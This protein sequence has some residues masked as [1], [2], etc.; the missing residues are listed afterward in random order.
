MG[1]AIDVVW[2][3][4]DWSSWESLAQAALMA[5]PRPGVYLG[6]RGATGE[7]LYVGHA[8]ERVHSQPGLRGRLGV[9][10]R[11]RGAVSGLGEAA[12][13]RALADPAFVRQRL[14]WLE[15]GRA[16]RTKDWARAALSWANVHVC[17]VERATKAE[18][19]AFED[20]LLGLLEAHVLWNR[21]RPTPGGAPGS[22]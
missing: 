18:A 5:P 16:E 12:L 13:D 14:H 1:D 11:G 17:W 8:G 4:A 21:K 9:Y 10:A 6:R 15:T 7:L 3:R 19:A 22:A 20:E 2:P